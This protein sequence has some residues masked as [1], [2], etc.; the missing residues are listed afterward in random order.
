[1]YQNG[2]VPPKPSGERKRR[3]Q[4]VPTVPPQMMDAA[5]HGVRR[6]T[7]ASSTG[8]GSNGQ[9]TMPQGYRQSAGQPASNGAA[10]YMGQS[11]PQGAQQGNGY[12]AGYQRQTYRQPQQGTYAQPQGSY[13]PPNYQQPV[14]QQQPNRDMYGTPAGY[15]AQGYYQ[16]APQS[17]RSG[18]GE[19]P[20]KGGRKWWIAVAAVVV[21][22]GLA[23]GGYFTMKRQSLVNEVN[24]YNNVFCEGVYVDGISL[25]GMTPEE[26]IA[27]VQARAQE[28]N[29]SWSVKLTFNGQ[30]VT[31]ITADQLGMT[32]DITD[33]MNQA[34]AQGHTG[35]VD[36]RKAA[37]DALAETHFEAYTAMPSGNT[38]VVDGILQD[39]RNNVYRAPQDAQLVSFDPSLSYPFTFQ[40]EMQ[41]RDLDTEPLKERLYQMVS[42]MESGEVEI[43]PMTI[44]PTVTVADLKRNLMERAT[45]STPISSKSTENRTNNI[46]RCFQLISGT[47]LKPGEKF[48]FNGVVGERSIKNGFYE[49]VEYAY[50]TEVMGVGGGSCQASTT[51]YQAAVEAGLTITDRTPHS[52]EVSYASY[53]EDA[54]VYW[55]SGRKIDLAFKNDTDHNIYVVAAVETDPS[56]KKRLVATTT[57]YGEDLGNIRYELQSSIVKEIEAPA[58]PEYVKDKN[59]TYVTYTDEEYQVSKARKGYEVESYRVTYENEQ[60]IARELLYTDTYAAKAARIYVGIKKRE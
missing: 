36:T 37:M 17:P 9:A 59:Q 5:A 25:G 7:S 49:A 51:V 10:Q 4:Q 45:V 38:S 27:A 43:V 31:E 1:M 44:A 46:R 3:A 22:A 53:G 6:D 18:G 34:W 24:A 26:G 29:S 56:N 23:C 54:T 39:I 58:E 28:R 42:T 57:I 14:Q 8:Y 13:Y 15:Q 35:D 32:V 21:V 55:S 50:G 11:A 47:I 20:K 16:Q 12:V 60:P 19:P 48:S 33:V 41:G 30:L 52:K 2:Y 40:N